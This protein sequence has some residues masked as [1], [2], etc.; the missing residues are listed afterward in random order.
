MPGCQS[1]AEFNQEQADTIA[2]VNDAIARLNDAGNIDFTNFA[3]MEA[4][5]SPTQRNIFHRHRYALE[6]IL[7]RELSLRN[8]GAAWFSGYLKQTA[9]LHILTQNLL[10]ER[11]L[12][13]DASAMTAHELLRDENFPRQW[14]WINAIERISGDPIY[15]A[16]TLT[17]AQ[18]SALRAE[19][20]RAVT[21]VQAGN[22]NHNALAAWWLLIKLGQFPTLD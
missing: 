2:T 13:A 15:K 1:T 17:D 12:Q 3:L 6:P 7:R 4:T 16:V 8:P 21:S 10:V 11:D 14:A 18:L 5:Y 22:P 20:A 19:A 9:H